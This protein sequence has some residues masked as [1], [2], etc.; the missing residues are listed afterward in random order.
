MTVLRTAIRLLGLTNREIE[1][2]LGM[3]PSYLGRIFGGSIEL[4]VEHVLAISRAMGLEPAEFFELAY[5]R[6]PDP[7][8]EAAKT[9]RKL[10]RDMQ[11]PEPEARPASMV[12]S[13]E[14]LQQ[15]IQES[16]RQALR[17]LAGGR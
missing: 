10:L 6:R 15:K 8:T 2:R 11:P 17:D 9:I 5:P 13:D 16:V 4:K 7:P 14:E 3:T 1:R 12:I